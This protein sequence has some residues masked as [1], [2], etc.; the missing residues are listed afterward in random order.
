MKEYNITSKEGAREFVL[1]KLALGIRELINSQSYYNLENLDEY[2]KF[3]I[4]KSAS[5]LINELLEDKKTNE[6]FT[7]LIL[8]SKINGADAKLKLETFNMIRNLISHFPFFKSWE[9]VIITKEILMWNNPSGQSIVKYFSSPEPR[10][11]SYKIYTRGPYD[12]WDEKKTISILIPTFI[13]EKVIILS[14]FISAENVLWTFCLIDSLLQ[15]LGIDVVDPSGY[16][17]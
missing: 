7:S 4:I 15:Y 6:K 17:V 1:E 10:N 3:D 2:E 13:E 14:K 11:I 16:S 9:E 8:E 12:S 5:E